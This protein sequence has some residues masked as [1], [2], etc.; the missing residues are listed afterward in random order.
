MIVFRGSPE[1]KQLLLKAGIQIVS[2][3]KQARVIVTE[4][5]DDDVLLKYQVPLIVVLTE[6]IN[7][8]CLTEI[9]KT[10]DCVTTR[11]N[12]ISALT[13][14]LHIKAHAVPESNDLKVLPID[15]TNDDKRRIKQWGS[16]ERIGKLSRPLLLA[17]FSTKGGVGKTSI[18]VNIA[19]W[20]ALCNKRTLLIDFDLGTGN[21][22]EVLGLPVS[23]GGMNVG[24]W[25]SYLNGIPEALRQHSSGLYLL[26]CSEDLSIGRQDVDEMLDVFSREFEVIVMDFGTKLFFSHTQAGLER[27]DKI[28]VSALQ[29]QG[30]AEVLYRRFAANHIEWINSGKA[31]LIVNR[32]SGIGYYLPREVA[33]LAGFESYL[34]IPEDTMAFESAKKHGNTVT[35]LRAS[36]AGPAFQE[37]AQTILS[38]I[39]STSDD[40]GFGI[41]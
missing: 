24:N 16:E 3:S 20:F 25:R 21:A 12:L 39:P 38:A 13:P 40:S 15:K 34:E 28:L 19:A 32:V 17:S 10:A 33:E 26:P 27:S 31:L 9:R 4:V 7:Y 8:E 23:I 35:Q 41:C 1:T 37:I 36:K 11:S 29:E 14:F 18:A 6:I 30:M 5:A 22:L 2:D